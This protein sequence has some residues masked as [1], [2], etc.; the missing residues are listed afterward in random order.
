[1]AN[2]A[3]K[4]TKRDF[5]NEML[6][7]I[8]AAKESGMSGFNFDWM[9]EM[10]TKEVVGLDKKAEQAKVR[11]Q[12]KK[13]SGDQLREQLYS[14][15]TPDLQT[16]AEILSAVQQVTG[17]TQLSAQK[18]TTRLGDLVSLGQA[19]KGEVSIASPDGGKSRKLTAYAR[20]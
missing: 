3:P 8:A 20:V 16:I 11:A 14:V 9:T 17:D 13:E 19:I 1:M 4:V 7:M 15:L 10:A 18:I 5:Y 12:K 6:S 2:T